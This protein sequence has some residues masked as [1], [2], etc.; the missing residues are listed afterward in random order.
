MN[1]PGDEE[2]LFPQQ[3]TP[4]WL[5]SPEEGLPD[6]KLFRGTALPESLRLG[7]H[8]P[9]PVDPKVKEFLMSEFIRYFHRLYG[10]FQKYSAEGI[11][12]EPLATYRYTPVHLLQAFLPPAESERDRGVVLPLWLIEGVKEK[13]EDVLLQLK[14]LSQAKSKGQKKRLEEERLIGSSVRVQERTEELKALYLILLAL[15]R[16]ARKELEGRTSDK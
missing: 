8:K 9:E 5:S 6:P 2:R 4:V 10:E 15:E 13:V 12:S 16:L 11:V 14:S 3:D 7:A 1:G